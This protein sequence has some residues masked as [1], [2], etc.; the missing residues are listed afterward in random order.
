MELSLDG[1]AVNEKRKKPAP[2][3]P[4]KRYQH[5]NEMQK[6]LKEALRVDKTFTAFYLHYKFIILMIFYLARTV[7]EPVKITGRRLIKCRNDI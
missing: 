2:I 6:N 4:I 7:L 5:L 1:A 3:A